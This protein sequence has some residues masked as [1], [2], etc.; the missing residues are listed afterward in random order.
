MELLTNIQVRKTTHSRIDEVD[1]D[2]LEFGKHISDHMLVCDYV[3]GEWQ[4]PHIVP[5]GNLVASPSTLALHLFPE[6]HGTVFI[7][8]YSP[9]LTS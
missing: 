3:H 4:T 6:F 8:Y 5:F 7:S 2:N 9:S 1:F